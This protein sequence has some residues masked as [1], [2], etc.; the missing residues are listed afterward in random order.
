MPGP[1]PLPAPKALICAGQK[2]PDAPDAELLALYS[3]HFGPPG[4]FASAGLCKAQ[5]QLGLALTRAIVE[6]AISNGARQWAYLQTSFDAARRQGLH[7]VEEYRLSR[8]RASGRM[9]DRTAPSKTDL[10][11][12]AVQPLGARLNRC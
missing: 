6:K 2:E 8:L 5:Q 9:V 7:S 10:L 12:R 4:S 1:L 11:A 3:S